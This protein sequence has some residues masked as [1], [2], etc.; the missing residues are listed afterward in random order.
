LSEPWS[1]SDRVGAG[2]VIEASVSGDVDVVGLPL[3]LDSGKRPVFHI[4]IQPQVVT[5]ASEWWIQFAPEWW[6]NM[7]LANARRIVACVN[8][9]RGISTEDLER[10]DFR[11]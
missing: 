6:K 1:Y 11:L 3:S 7:Q 5:I 9:C 2:I 10:D 4:N 8:A